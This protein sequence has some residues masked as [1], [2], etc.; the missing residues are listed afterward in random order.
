M[1]VFIKLQTDVLD[2][3][4]DNTNCSTQTDSKL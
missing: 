2:S 3:R 1:S 4:Q